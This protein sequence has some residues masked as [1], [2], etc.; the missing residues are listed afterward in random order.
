M[1]QT[2][3]LTSDVHVVGNSISIGLKIVHVCKTS[4]LGEGGRYIMGA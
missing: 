2:T 3:C 4:N 1:Y